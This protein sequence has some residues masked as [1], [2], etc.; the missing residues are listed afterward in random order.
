V[1]FEGPWA[2]VLAL[3]LVQEP[4]APSALRPDLDPRL[5]VVC[6]KAMAKHPGERFAT[7]GE[8]AQALQMWPSRTGQSANLVLPSVHPD[9]DALTV[10]EPGAGR[11][12]APR[13]FR[14]RKRWAF[15]AAVVGLSLLAAWLVAIWPRPVPDRDGAPAAGPVVF[16][17]SA[18]VAP[19]TAPTPLQEGLD[20]LARQDYDQAIACL[21]R[22][23]AQDP[24]TVAASKAGGQV[25]FHRKDYE[26]A[27]A[28]YT[29]A[30]QRDDHDAG[31]H[32]ERGQAY[33]GQ[34]DYRRALADGERARQLD[35]QLALA[36]RV[37]GD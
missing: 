13:V 5:E 9:D 35:P 26:Q 33:L 10:H 20:A 31:A 34:H 29:K 18:P 27:V 15:A 37:C 4:P 11:R 36:H 12:A 6:R 3:V 16:D 25:Y 1:P 7:M 30:L 23:L 8:L 17:E 32:V 28:D 2:A 14:A 22:A 21:N 24:Q 19:P